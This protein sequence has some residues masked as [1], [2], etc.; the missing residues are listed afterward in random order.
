MKYNLFFKLILFGFICAFIATSCVKEGPMGPAGADGEDGLDGTNGLNGSDGT[1]GCIVCHSSNQLLFAMENQWSTSMHANGAA[2]ERNTGE[3]AI[4]HT[5]QGFLGNL[6][7]SYAYGAE[8]AMISNPNPQNC[9]TCH[10]IHK[11]FT[12]ADLSLTVSGPVVLRNT[13]GQSHDFGKGSICASCHQGRTV[14][15]W[16]VAGGD[17]IQAGSRYGIHHGPQGNV[18]AGVGMGLFEVGDGLV[19][20]VHANIENT[21][22]TCHMAEPYGTQAGG[23]TWNMTYVYHGA[24]AIWDA[25]C[26]STSC[27][28][29][30]EDI[31]KLAEEFQTEINL[32]LVELKTLLDTEGITRPGSDSN[33]NG[34]Y[35]A[36]VAGAYIDYLALTEDGSLG[37]HNPKYVKKLLENLIDELS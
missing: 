18:I 29:A 35:P 15:I 5:S 37:I 25:G 24:D 3:C 17:S 27:H 14:A 26:S 6:D 8:G 28:P 33:V 30:G 19:N 9:Y 31:H 10:N 34:K 1:A 21:C 36:V 11:T 23:H 22:V 13:G 16:P 2:F 20:S 7:G 12:S 4:C 32:L